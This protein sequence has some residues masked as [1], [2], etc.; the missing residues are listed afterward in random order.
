MPA[1][2]MD[3]SALPAPLT[4][5]LTEYHLAMLSTLDRDGAPHLVPV[6]VTLDVEQQC[7]WVI[8]RRGSQK[9]T[10]IRRDPRVAV[11]QVDRGRWASLVGTGQVR[12][13]EESI[14][15]ACELYAARYRPPQ[16]NPERVAIRITIDRV[17]GQAALL[18]ES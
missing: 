7:A 17:L 6:G 12:E 2:T 16:P 14:A 13:D 5:F 18:P 8:T 1:W 15:R 10:N 4:D 3:W 11:G 9:V